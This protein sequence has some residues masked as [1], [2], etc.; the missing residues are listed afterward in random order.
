MQD[1]YRQVGPVSTASSQNPP[2]A[3]LCSPAQH[4]IATER[5]IGIGAAG[6]IRSSRTVL[7][8]S[9]GSLF[10]IAPALLRHQSCF[11]QILPSQYAPA[12]GTGS[13]RIATA[14]GRLRSARCP[15]FVPPTHG[16][17]SRGRWSNIGT[18]LNR[19]VRS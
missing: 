15:R 10:G 9:R 5:E 3:L 7:G 8:R 13:L 14:V 11:S 4:P 18:G 19:G 6:L 1:S 17:F 2:W 16:V 12:A